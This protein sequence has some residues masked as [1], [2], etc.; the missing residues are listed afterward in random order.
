[1]T[2]EIEKS[3]AKKKNTCSNLLNLG[4]SIRFTTRKISN[5]YLI[6]KLNYELI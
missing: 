3:R 2:N 5:P 4:N 6:K 1:M